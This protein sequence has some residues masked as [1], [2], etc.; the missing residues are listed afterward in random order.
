MPPDVR[1]FIGEDDGTPAAALRT[2]VA[3]GL[4]VA[5]EQQQ[6]QQTQQTPE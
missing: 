2:R 1:S 5:L 3:A 4:A 6:M